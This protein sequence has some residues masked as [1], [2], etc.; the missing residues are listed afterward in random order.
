LSEE[1]PGDPAGALLEC[2]GRPQPS[3]LKL[4]TMTKATEAKFSIKEVAQRFRVHATTV[5]RL[6]DKGKL[7][8]Y[9]IGGRRIVGEGHIEQYLSFAERKAKSE[10]T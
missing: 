10:R 7:G 2:S 5:Y 8:F 9:Q 6:M 3:L 1:L 4:Q